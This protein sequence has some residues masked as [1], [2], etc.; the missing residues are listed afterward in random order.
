MMVRIDSSISDFS[1]QKSQSPNRQANGSATLRNQCTRISV[2]KA[3]KKL[4][5]GRIN[6]RTNE[7]MKEQYAL[8]PSKREESIMNRMNTL[9]KMSLRRNDSD[10]SQALVN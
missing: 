7:Y 6:T 1:P 5:F 3:V 2:E 9:S 8:S 10:F 4:E